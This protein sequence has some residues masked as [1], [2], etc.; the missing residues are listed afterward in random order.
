MIIGLPHVALA[1]TFNILLEEHIDKLLGSL[2]SLVDV[3]RV[4]F[5]IT[6]EFF[7]FAWGLRGAIGGKVTSLLLLLLGSSRA[8]S[9]RPLTGRTRA[10]GKTGPWRGTQILVGELLDQAIGAVVGIW[11]A[12]SV[13]WLGRLLG[14][15]LLLHG[16]MGLLRIGIADKVALL[17]LLLLLSIG[18]SLGTMRVHVVLALVDWLRECGGC[19]G[20]H[21]VVGRIVVPLVEA[22]V[23][24]QAIVV[25]IHG[26]GWTREPCPEE[27]AVVCVREDS[28][29]RGERRCSV[30][31]NVDA[32]PRAWLAEGRSHTTRQHD[33]EV[34][35]TPLP[36]RI[37]TKTMADNDETVLAELTRG[38][39]RR[40]EVQHT[41][42]KGGK[43][44]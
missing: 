1:R 42:T 38:W 4:P 24:V 10:W 16:V 6:L 15:R 40:E 33:N 31:R 9:A 19:C 21:T 13:G 23:Q 29:R 25:R 14:V 28:R 22:K 5:R 34:C 43:R 7:F 30:R 2:S 27:E 39:T 11:R 41:P 12:G 8:S 3:L 35:R 44:D 36:I 20:V 17:L 32:D 37:Q 18:I 26:E